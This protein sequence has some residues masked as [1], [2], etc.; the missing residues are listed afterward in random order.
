[1]RY[2]N[3]VAFATSTCHIDQF[4][5]APQLFTE[6]IIPEELAL[7]AGASS[8]TARVEMAWNIML[9][10]DVV[11]CLQDMRALMQRLLRHA[12]YSQIVQLLDVT[13]GIFHM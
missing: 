3:G 10:C 9:R 13:S 2:A 6:Y 12:M 5:H 11:R 1:M 7:A 8:R 4:L